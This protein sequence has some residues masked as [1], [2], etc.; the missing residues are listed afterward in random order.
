VLG[1][2]LAL[3]AASAC[4]G[5]G[6]VATKA[7][8]GEVP[9]LALLVVQLVP[10]VAFLWAAVPL[11]RAPLR[12]DRAAALAALSGLLEPGLAYT[13]GLFG[14]RLTL[15]S[16]A[17][18]IGA[19]ETPMTV[20]LAAVFLRERIGGRTLLRVAAAAA[21][22]ALVVLPHAEGLGDGAFL[23]DVLVGVA[24][25]LAAA[26]VTVSRRLVGGIAPLPLA[27][28]QQTVGLLWALLALALCRGAAAPFRLS[29]PTAL[30]AAATGVVQYA[31]SF[32]LYLSALRR[33][34]ANRAALYLTLIPVFG[35]AGAAAALGERLALVQWVG[36]AVVVGAVQAVVRADRRAAGAA[37]ARP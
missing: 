29:L 24:A 32:W 18:L 3:V 12:L 8:L 6:T 19:A 7:L 36:A 4:W 23:G 34:P 5:L 21:G 9:P 35:V 1:A 11:T 14:L 26:Y 33:V 31:F 17:A 16:S 28:L 20:L 10:S 2:G 22:V 30:W 13:V 25:L 15:A 37:T 27:A